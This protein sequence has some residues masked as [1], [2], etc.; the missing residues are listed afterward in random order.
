MKLTISKAKFETMKRKKIMKLLKR[1][2][3]ITVVR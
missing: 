1:G 3:A 2:F